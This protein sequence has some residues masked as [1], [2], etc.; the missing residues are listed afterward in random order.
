[1]PT[2]AT[3]D[4]CQTARDACAIAVT[5]LSAE[6]PTETNASRQADMQDAADKTETAT[7]ALLQ[8]VHPGIEP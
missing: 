4:K 3:K 6:I 2:Q 5:A 8:V 7:T 1:M